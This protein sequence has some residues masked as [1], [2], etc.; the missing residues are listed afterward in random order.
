MNTAKLNNLEQVKPSILQLK[1][2]DRSIDDVKKHFLFIR[3]S[4]TIHCIKKSDILYLRA[5][6]NYTEIFSIGGTKI[7]CSKTLKYFNAILSEST[8][9]R[10]HQSYIVNLFQLRNL[11]IGKSSDLELICGTR[12]PISRSKLKSIQN[13]LQN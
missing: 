7:I 3:T 6:S 2:H 8:F 10:S 12:I 9:F 13:R 11:H 4:Q 5:S 1:H